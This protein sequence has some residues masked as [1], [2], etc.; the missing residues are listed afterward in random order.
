MLQ[1]CWLIQAG[2]L[3]YIS[4]VLSSECLASSIS[5]FL[6]IFYIFLYIF[7]S[8]MPSPHPCH[9]FVVLQPRLSVQPSARQEQN[10]ISVIPA[11]CLA[12]EQHKCGFSSGSFAE[13]SHSHLS[14][15]GFGASLSFQGGFAGLSSF[16]TTPGQGVRSSLRPP[17][18]F[19]VA[20]WAPPPSSVMDKLIF[21]SAGG[22]VLT[23]P[24]VQ[25]CSQ[26]CWLRG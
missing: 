11:R 9:D 14:S 26:S 18:M 25:G 3:C 7:I 19:L 23:V 10:T 15:A 21:P 16:T 4:P 6:Y 12:L 24:A 17:E 13:S 22:Q 5:P 20:R 1:C 8:P 2:V